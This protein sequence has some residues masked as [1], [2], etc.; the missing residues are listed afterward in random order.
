M[1]WDESVPAI[2]FFVLF[3]AVAALLGVPAT[4]TAAWSSAPG[5]GG[6]ISS[7]AVADADSWLAKVHCCQ[8]E[9]A[10][11]DDAG[12]NW[13]PILLPDFDEAS[14][15]GAAADGSFRLVA[16]D[17]LS[18]E[19]DEMQV[20]RVDSSGLVE[21]VGAAI[22]DVS[23]S[24]SHTA[25]GIT[26]EGSTWIPFRRL[27]DSQFELRTVAA[28]GSDESIDL[29]LGGSTLRWATEQTV[30]GPRLLRYGS[31]GLFLGT[32]AVFGEA[33]VP[34]EPYP[35]GYVDGD[36]WLSEPF[37]RVSWDAGAHWTES[38]SGRPVPRSPGLGSPR[39]LYG[40]GGIASRY[41]NELFRRSGLGWPAGVPQGRVTD[42]GEALVAWGSDEILVH[43]GDLPPLSSAI[44]QL[45]PDT[46]A[47][48]DRAN[49]LRADAGLPPLVA[50]AQVSQ[51]ARNHSLYTFLNGTNGAG[52][53]SAHD[54][55]EG[56]PGFT[57][58]HF[59]ARC[60]FVGTTCSEE[61]M[62]G[63]GEVDPAAGWLAT[64]YHRPLLGSPKSGVVGIARVAGGASVAEYHSPA[65]IQLEP[66][67]YPSGVWR[68][69]AGFIGEIPDPVDRCAEAGQ[70]ISYPIGIAI[71]LYSPVPYGYSFNPGPVTS[72]EV[73]R[74]GHA[75]A[76]PGCLLG[77]DYGDT[78]TAG[79]FVLDDRLIAGETYD[80]HGVWNTGT[81]VRGAG[82][83]VPGAEMSYAWSF[84]FHPDA[85]VDEET[86]PRSRHRVTCGG[87]R[88][89]LIGSGKRD[90]LRGTRRRDVIAALGGNDLIHGLDGNDVL[91]GGGGRDRI[92]GQNGRDRIYGQN[93]P[94][95]IYGQRGRDRLYGGRGRDRLWGGPSRDLL[96]GGRGQDS[97]RQ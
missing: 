36:F 21:P 40:A 67:G 85:P 71:T 52:S 61:I 23:S 51:A 97:E 87:L 41:S 33:A 11:T 4:A 84:V 10:V 53:L 38:D 81:D 65:N 66:V 56:L 57:G 43:Q 74:R 16:W 8:P 44:G 14:I 93:G 83:L 58:G 86:T 18:S 75:E 27:S 6:D 45:E 76:L 17:A 7:L 30:F 94:D 15:A 92:Y 89:T 28:D 63:S 79:M 42:A 69:A 72:I 2:R 73:H 95:G 19:A 96:R 82:T 39:Y 29:P 49:Q 70:P 68:G 26:P 1:L 12:Q 31:G 62:F 88:A 77:I 64:V 3:A 60:E 48:L 91:C 78:G 9:F 80:A 90:R 22:A 25:F 13:T 55:I 47:I 35:V 32:Y 46:Q 59:T 24:T 20:L 37:T 5:P 54:E 50:D 34:A